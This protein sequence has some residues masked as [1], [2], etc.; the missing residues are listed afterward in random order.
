MNALLNWNITVC[1]LFH[2]FKNELH[3]K[4]NETR[5]DIITICKFNLD[6]RGSSRTSAH[7]WRDSFCKVIVFFRRVTAS[8]SLSI[9]L[10]VIRNTYILSERYIFY[11]DPFELVD[12][13]F[14][15]VDHSFER[16]IVVW[17]SWPLFWASATLWSES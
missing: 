3:F 10:N 8:L 7:L 5:L 9:R 2:I 11:G 13:S 15:L 4:T 16:V 1:F 17:A 14:E 6:A 12:H